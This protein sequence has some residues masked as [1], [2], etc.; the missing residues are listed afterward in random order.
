[1]I[2]PKIIRIQDSVILIGLNDGS[3]KEVRKEDLSFEPT[4][5]M[6]V[7]IFENESCT[8]ITPVE[9]KIPKTVNSLTNSFTVPN[10]ASG[11]LVNK[12]TYCLLA[13]FLGGIGIHKFYGGKTGTGILFLLF[14]WTGIPAIIALIDLIIGICKPANSQGQIVI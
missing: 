12:L 5:G 2:M 10:P 9:M 4:L 1:M 14:C 8:I 3:I 11:K 6:M 7:D 13:F